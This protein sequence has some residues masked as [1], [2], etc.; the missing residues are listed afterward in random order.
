MNKAVFDNRDIQNLGRS[1][2]LIELLKEDLD[3]LSTQIEFMIAE[4][5]ESGEVE[6]VYGEESFKVTIKE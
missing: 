4:L 2:K 3:D 1:E 5:R 6:I